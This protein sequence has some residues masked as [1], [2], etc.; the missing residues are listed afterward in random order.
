M[1]LP[2]LDRRAVE[3]AERLIENPNLTVRSLSA[4]FNISKTTVH[5]DLTER[6]LGV[7]GVLAEKVKNILEHHKE[8]RH[9]NGGEATKKM[10]ART[11][12]KEPIK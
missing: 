12:Q 3:I 1:A 5:A 4:E 2:C 10:K 11:K 8:I 7:D 6:L 9:F